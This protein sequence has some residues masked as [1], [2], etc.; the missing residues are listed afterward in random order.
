MPLRVGID[1]WNLPGDTRGIGRYVREIVRRWAAWGP[2]KIC[3]TLLVPEW[4]SLFVRRRY[5]WEVGVEL[6]VKHRRAERQMDVVWYPWNGVSWR[7][8]API[9]ATLHDASQFRMPPADPEV[10]GREQRPFLEAAKVARRLI[11][12]SQFSKA[13]LVRYLEVDPEQIDV[14][15]LGVNDIFRANDSPVQTRSRYLLFVGEPERRKG[16][17]T[18]L[19]AM[20]LLPNRLKQSTEIV[21]AGA[22]GEHLLPEAPAGVRMRNVG[23]VSDAE[24][25]TLY[26]QAMALVY[27]SE[28]E[29]FGLPIV[30][31]MA[32]GTP[33]IAADTPSSREAAGDAALYASPSDPK[34]LAERIQAVLGQPELRDRLR[35]LGFENVRERCWERTAEE[36]FASIRRSLS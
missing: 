21:V 26:R 18:L 10:R 22:R 14:V 36:T 17:S 1:A 8:T 11:T 16:L 15:Y 3:P 9:V 23:W 32:S 30:E 7:A 12:D 5:L 6:P 31:A 27:P 2:Q 28:Y 20:A 25:A 29:G 34:S 35:T 24:L 33:V 4:A 13:E 19:E